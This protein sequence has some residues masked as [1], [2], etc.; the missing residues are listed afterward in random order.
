MDHDQFKVD[1]IVSELSER[2][3]AGNAADAE[4]EMIV[5]RH[6]GL[7]PLRSAHVIVKA[8]GISLPEMKRI[9]LRVES[10]FDL[11]EKIARFHERAAEFLRKQEADMAEYGSDA[12]P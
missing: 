12:I 2:I 1:L 7:S 5:L 4:T 9:L 6:K 3:Q 8:F 11:Q 10:P